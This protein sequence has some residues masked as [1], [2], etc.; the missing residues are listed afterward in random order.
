MQP[1]NYDTTPEGAL[2]GMLHLPLEGRSKD[3]EERTSTRDTFFILIMCLIKKPK[4][5]TV[6]HRIGGW[7][8]ISTKLYIIYHE[9]YIF[10][11]SLFLINMSFKDSALCIIFRLTV[12]SDLAIKILTFLSTQCFI[13]SADEN[14]RE[15]P[16]STWLHSSV[17]CSCCQES[18]DSPGFL[19]V[20][21]TQERNALGVSG[22][23]SETSYHS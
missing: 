15:H 14:R 22:M 20:W 23:N 19:Y 18:C 13:F 1:T 7:L 12:S 5:V 9:A 17:N 4:N 10:F 3:G 16:D 11:V 2:S 8:F 21:V 6:F